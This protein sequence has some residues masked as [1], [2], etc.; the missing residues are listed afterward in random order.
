M[1]GVWTVYSPEK[2]ILKSS[3]G[4]RTL[5][6]NTDKTAIA[7]INQFPLPDGSTQQK[8]WQIE[9]ESC[10]LPDG[11][12]HPADP[13]KRALALTDDGSSAWVPLKLKSNHRFSVELFLKHEDW[14][15]SIGSI[16]AENGDLEKILHLREHLNTFPEVNT[17]T[18]ITNLS[19][20]W[21][22]IKQSITPD[23]NISV[24]EEITELILD[25]TEGKN[26]TF[27]LPENVIVNIPKKVQVGEAFAIVSGQLMTG[28]KYQRLTAQYDSNGAFTILIL[29]IFTLQN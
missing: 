7:H 16:Y 21:I 15:T 12:L 5:V 2:E 17:L 11:L 14:N 26:E 6:A 3:Q 25:P 10:N 9:K 23:L 22:G 24:P 19:G 13:S 18:E 4:I 27:F 20:N 29:E 28:N 1:Y 8:Q